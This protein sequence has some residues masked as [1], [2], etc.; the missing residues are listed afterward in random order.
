MT[1]VYGYSA[2]HNAVITRDVKSVR[3]LT[4]IPGVCD[5]ESRDSMGFTP[6]HLAT[7]QGKQ[8]LVQM[9]EGMTS[10]HISSEHTGAEDILCV[11]AAASCDVNARNKL[12][13]TALHLAAKQGNIQNLRTLLDAGSD[14]N[15]KDKLGFTA[16]GLAFKFNQKGS[17]DV[18]LHYK[19]RRNQ[20][21]ARKR[22][23]MKPF[24]R[25][26]QGLKALRSNCRTRQHL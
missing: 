15:I 13:R 17:A 10:L 21:F 7:L 23:P 22:F 19:P 5:V 16:V 20:S 6:L 11:L 4:A 8:D 12:G 18:L 24:L 14:R 26:L 1:E 3:I 9:L 2:L 25:K